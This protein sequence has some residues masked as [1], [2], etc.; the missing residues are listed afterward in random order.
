MIKLTPE[1]IIKRYNRK[2]IDKEMCKALLISFLENSDRELE[3]LKSIELLSNF[4]F[5][6]LK[7]YEYFEQFFVSD[8]NSKI[9]L[10]AFDLIIKNYSVKAADLITWTLDNEKSPDII[11]GIL[12]GAVKYDPK[13]IRDFLIGE[14]K[15][16]TNT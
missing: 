11:A 15:T 8:G 13:R 14:L 3:R 2:K 1:K 16:I 4:E 7:D 6:D 12:K 10:F 5:T 9:R